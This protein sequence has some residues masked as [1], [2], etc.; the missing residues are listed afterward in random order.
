[1]ELWNTPAGFDEP[2]AAL[3]ACHRRI[4]KQ[5]ATLARL[6]KHLTRNVCDEESITAAAGILRYFLDA[7]PNHHA[8]EESD[9]FPRLLRA[10]QATT[11]HALAYELVSRLLVEHRDMEL[12]WA[13][14]REE[15]EKL[16][17]GE[18]GVL[19]LEL[20]KN[21]AR[22][23][24]SHIDRE[25]N[26]LLPLANRVLTSKELEALGNAMAKRRGLDLPFPGE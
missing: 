11:D 23:Y 1:M 17:P 24:A 20:C 21:F 4:E 22:D 5:L 26:Q 10:A 9:L 15:L 3:S 7:A 16:K 18:I 12:I 13:R 14:V 19:D 2:L 8:D 6:Q 25:D